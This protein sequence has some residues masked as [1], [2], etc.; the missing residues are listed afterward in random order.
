M[1]ESLKVIFGEGQDL[2]AMQMSLRALAVFF[3]ILVFLRLSGQRLLGM[4]MPLDYAVIMLLGAI[5]ARAI[6]GA[7][8][9]FPTVAAAA[10]LVLLHRMSAW[11]SIKSKKWGWFAKGED[12]KVF[13]NGSFLT[14]NM[15]SCLVTKHDLAEG[16][17]QNANIESF[18]DVKSIYVERNGQLSI[19][20]KE[21]K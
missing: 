14:D 11:L 13:E 12:R 8:P 19:I 1:R 20:K 9:F 5:L 4:K 21:K 10:T 7:S 15:N 2:N 3:I 18:D 17:R 6:L 16:I